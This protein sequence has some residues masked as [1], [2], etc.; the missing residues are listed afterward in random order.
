MGQDYLLLLLLLFLE[1]A[2]PYRRLK[3]SQMS[4]ASVFFSFASVTSD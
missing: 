1:P 4:P 3:A 2:D